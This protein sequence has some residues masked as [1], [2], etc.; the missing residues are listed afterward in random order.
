[1]LGS[2]GYLLS[3]LIYTA[4]LPYKVVGHF[5]FKAANTFQITIDFLFFFLERF[6]K[7]D[8]F[9]VVVCFYEQSFFFP[10]IFISWRLITLQL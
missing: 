10:F 5:T 3:V 6:S 7:S 8:L 1:M 4:K 2:G 9:V